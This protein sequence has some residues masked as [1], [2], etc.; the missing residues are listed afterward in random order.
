MNRTQVFGIKVRAA[1][2]LSHCD[3]TVT[4]VDYYHT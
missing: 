1:S 3:V 2:Q 4:Y